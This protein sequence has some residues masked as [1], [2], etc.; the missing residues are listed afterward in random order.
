M[1]SAMFYLLGLAAFVMIAGGAIAFF[2][3]RSAPEGYED[4]DGFVGVTK[5]DEF[6]LKQFAKEHNYA[7]LHGSI[8]AAA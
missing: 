3:L 5:G 7:A 2:A 1:H 8:D 4:E 6:L